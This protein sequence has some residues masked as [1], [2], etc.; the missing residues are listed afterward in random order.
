MRLSPAVALLALAA[1]GESLPPDIG[2]NKNAI[3]EVLKAY[4][5]AGDQ[6]DVDIMAS[7]LAPEATIFK[8]AEDFAR[9]KEEAV[10]ELTDRVKY[11]QGQSR[12]TLL[13]REEINITGDVGVA[14][15]VASV[16]TQR[17]GI[18]AV[19]RRTQGKWQISHLHE[20]W[21]APAPAPK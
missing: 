8:G 12:S 1:C 16:G 19:L 5:R 18:T 6:G 14:T 3:W 10:K 21:P 13:G 15:Y 17:A 7:H 2:A 11:F 9:P 20:S 4:H